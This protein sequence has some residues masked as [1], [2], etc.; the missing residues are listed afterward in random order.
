M[1][2]GPGLGNINLELLEEV[3]LC[4]KHEY[5]TKLN[6]GHNLV[7]YKCNRYWCIMNLKCCGGKWSML[8]SRDYCSI[9][10]KVQRK[11]TKTS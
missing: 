4:K 5:L 9:F 10:R 11:T 8:N 7:M 2:L 3:G 1:V 6:N